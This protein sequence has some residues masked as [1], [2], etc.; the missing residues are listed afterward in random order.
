MIF[1]VGDP[2]TRKPFNNEPIR[3]GVITKVSRSYKN[4]LG[5]SFILYSVRWNDT[6]LEEQGYL[7]IANGL[8]L[9]QKT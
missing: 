5:E 8:E 1:K 3:R 7:G 9:D 6:G 4:Y 2:V